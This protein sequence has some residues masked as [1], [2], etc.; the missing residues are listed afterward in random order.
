MLLDLFH[1]DSELIGLLI[2]QI[3][4]SLHVYHTVGLVPENQEQEVQI[5]DNLV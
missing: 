1:T 2:I 3:L 4:Q 5:L